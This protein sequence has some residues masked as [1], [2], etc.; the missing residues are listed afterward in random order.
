MEDRK[1]D[2]IR[3]ALNSQ[4]KKDE[5][6]SR[7]DYE[8]MLGSETEGQWNEFDFLGKRMKVPMWVSSMTGGAPEALHINQNLAK[9][10]KKFG[11]GMGLGSCRI[12]LDNKRHLPD[13]NVR[14]IIGDD[15]PLYANIGIA[16]LEKMMKKGEYDRL[17]NLVSLLRADGIIIHVNPSQES[18]QEEGDFLHFRPIDTLKDFLSKT[19]LKIIVK[20]VGQGMGPR[21]LKELMLLP[22]EAIETASF[23]GTNFARL[24]LIRRSTE[25]V[26]HL[27]PLTHVGHTAEAMI[28][29]I[30]GIVE[31]NAEIKCK[32]LIIS[33]GIRSHLDG[34]YLI[35][36]SKLPA[37]YG[38][39]S[40]YL[41]HASVSYLSLEKYIE[42]QILGLRFSKAW[43][44]PKFDK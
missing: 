21:S 22:I 26:S 14:E 11:M 29:I 41:R 1:G 9:A 6:D 18:L 20:E 13:F 8:P 35:S 19:E 17:E 15:L 30:N 27:E 39:A 7:F 43:L 5:I 3:L 31:S 34:Y 25:N 23:G 2:H 28:D 40:G 44:Y 4:L 16:Q 37:V 36:K 12:L 24:E 33:G 10:C 38:Q 32:Q 42:E